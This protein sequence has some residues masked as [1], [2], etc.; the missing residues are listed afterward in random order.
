MSASSAISLSHPD[1]S[2]LESTFGEI[3]HIAYAGYWKYTFTLRF[4]CSAL[5]GRIFAMDVG[6][7]ADEIYAYEPES[8][9]WDEHCAAGVRYVEEV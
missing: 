4:E 3:T 5:P 6:G 7:S 2:A 1:L 9:D 8:R